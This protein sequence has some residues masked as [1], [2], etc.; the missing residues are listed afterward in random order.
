MDLDKIYKHCA[1]DSESD[2]KFTGKLPLAFLTAWANSGASLTGKLFKETCLELEGLACCW[3]FVFVL[4]LPL[5]KPVP[6]A[7]KTMAKITIATTKTP[8]IIFLFFSSLLDWLLTLLGVEVT[9]FL[10]LISLPQCL[11][12]F[13]PSLISFPHLGQNIKLFDQYVNQL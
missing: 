9:F 13:E 6:K 5:N 12:N 1:F 10:L 2:L 4:W 3:L 11:Q 8:I 7:T